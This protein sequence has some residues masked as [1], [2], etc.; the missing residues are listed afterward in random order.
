MDYVLQMSLLLK[1]R[2]EIDQQL[3]E[4]NKISKILMESDPDTVRDTERSE[5]Q[6]G[7]AVAE[8]NDASNGI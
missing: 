6:N 2:S 1:Q 4:M 5:E 7:Q 8:L 3:A